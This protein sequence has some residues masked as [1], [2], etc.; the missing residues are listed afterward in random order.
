MNRY[1]FAQGNFQSTTTTFTTT[2]TQAGY[3]D[4]FVGNP[5][6]RIGSPDVFVGNPFV[7]HDPFPGAFPGFPG[8]M[9]M[10]QMHPQ[11]L[12]MGLLSLL[13]PRLNPG[14]LSNGQVGFRPSGSG[15][16]VAD[17]LK[18]YGN[19]PK[20][21]AKALGVGGSKDTKRI[22]NAVKAL[23]QT[24]GPQATVGG[25][26]GI[27]GE[28]ITLPPAL[29]N[30]IA[31]CGCAKTGQQKLRTWLEQQAGTKNDREILNK[32]MGTKIKRGKEKDSGSKLMLETMMEQSVKT[33]QSGRMLDFCGNPTC[34]MPC[35]HCPVQMS[36]NHAKYDEAARNIASLASPLSLDL[37]GDGKLTSDKKV[38][39][40]IDGDGKLDTVNDI[41]EGDALLV[42]DADGDGIAGENGQ[43][44]L[45]DNTDLDGDGQADG[46]KDGF[47]ALEALARK[48][49]LISE[50]DTELSAQDLKV[51]QDKY[52]LRLRRGSLNGHDQTFSAADIQALRVGTGASRRESNFDGLGND[53][54]R[55]DGAGFVRGDGSTGEM[56]DIWFQK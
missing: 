56:A 15:S 51:L 23:S 11:Q 13:A 27:G 25:Q 21:M 52:G 45:G 1:G 4:A 17:L 33:L 37:D 14:L 36:F 5:Y 55:R 39:F 29:A 35:Y 10:F 20:G 7:R 6:R 22:N 28:K 53:V 34:M 47:E 43:E 41:D 19:N 31:R 50:G 9:P 2:T 44:L 54:S 18:K 40:D 30:E 3:P 24:P 12:M 26:A 38:Q 46:Y 42:F 8:L 49:G 48:E 16:R 32:I